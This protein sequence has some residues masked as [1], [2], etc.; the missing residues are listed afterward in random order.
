MHRCLHSPNQKHHM[1]DDAWAVM[2]CHEHDRQHSLGALCAIW[3]VIGL[4]C[5]MQERL[6]SPCLQ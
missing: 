6:R 1:V 4:P 5:K 2:E 3:L